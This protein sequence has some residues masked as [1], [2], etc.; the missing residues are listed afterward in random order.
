MTEQI[1]IT[2]IKLT[3]TNAVEMFGKGHKYRDLL[4]FEPAE[5]WTVGIDPDE[6]EVG[7]MTNCLI[8]VSYELSDKLT[9]KGNPYKDIVSLEL[10]AG[11]TRS[12]SL[13]KTETSEKVVQGLRE[14]Y[15]VNSGML[16]T[17]GLIS[18][19]LENVSNKLLQLVELRTDKEAQ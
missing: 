9:S 4:L 13:A 19:Q 6:L 17:L 15:K 5:L 11:V 14:L 8:Q 7:Q 18:D 2:R 12:P 3:E 1:L 16:S 10:P